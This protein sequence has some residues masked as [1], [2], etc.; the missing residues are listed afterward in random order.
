MKQCW[1]NNKT[2]IITGGASGIGGGI[3]RLLIT[4]YA[5]NVIAVIIDDVGLAQILED[6]GENR[7]RF[8]YLYYD[9][10]RYESWAEIK[11]YL[12]EHAIQADVLINNAG[13][14][15]SFERFENTGREKLERCINVDF[16]S[17][18]Y[19]MQVLYPHIGRSDTPAFVTVSSSAALAPLAGTSLYTAAKSAS[20][21]LTECF[22]CEH[23]EIYVG[24][25]CPGFTKTNLFAQQKESMAENKLIAAFMSERDT[26]VRK[27]V[28][29]IRR[30][31]RRMVYGADARVMGFLYKLFPK[32]FPKLCRR[33]MKISRQKVFEDIFV[34]TDGQ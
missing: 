11:Q 8:T 13:I 4:E 26:M 22:A 30:K 24:C 6:L 1:L 34:K 7:E 19:S 25:V 10:S 27:I 28:R 33:I 15:P 12:E 31:K 17:V 29:G 14:F 16:Y 21:A 5:C 18:A 9:V 3:A 20:K 23:P 32:S 2:V